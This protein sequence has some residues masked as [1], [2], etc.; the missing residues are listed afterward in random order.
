MVHYLTTLP[1]TW[2]LVQSLPLATTTNTFV[3][4]F[5]SFF[6]PLLCSA[7]SNCKRVERRGWRE[8]PSGP[9][10]HNSS[11]S[12]TKKKE[13]R[14]PARRDIL[15]D[16]WMNHDWDGRTGG[17]VGLALRYGIVVVILVLVAASLSQTF[18]N[19]SLCNKGRM[20]CILPLS[21]YGHQSFRI[22]S[23]PPSLLHL[24]VP[25]QKGP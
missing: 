19:G 11:L 18:D 25:K 4:F 2:L 12:W 23:F 15:A 6:F 7:C 10:A 1:M 22:H 24:S 14:E 5:T 3:F 17:S 21:L 16:G 13:E 8:D 20:A 9:T